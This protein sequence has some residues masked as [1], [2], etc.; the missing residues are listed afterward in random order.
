MPPCRAPS[1]VRLVLLERLNDNADLSEMEQ[2]LDTLSEVKLR[3]E[4]FV[5]DSR[6]HPTL[7]FRQLVQ[8]LRHYLQV[9][10]KDEDDGILNCESTLRKH[11]QARQSMAAGTADNSL[12]RQLSSILCSALKIQTI[13]CCYHS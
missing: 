5:D 6:K 10:K 12:V 8:L 4:E 11:R 2:A 13:C 3:M 1:W 9:P 7:T